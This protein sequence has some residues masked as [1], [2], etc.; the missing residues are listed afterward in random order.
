MIRIKHTLSWA[1]PLLLLAASPVYA[2]PLHGD[3]AG[4]FVRGLLHPLLGID[5]LLAMVAVGVWAA[6]LGGSAVWKV[7]PAF[8]ITMLIGAG[9]GLAGIGLPLIE[10]MIAASVVVLGLVIA[11]QVRM[12]AWLASLLVA[13]FALFHGHA[14]M[15]ELPAGALALNYIVGF[16][17]TTAT[18]HGAGIAM[19]YLLHRHASNALVR[20]GGIGLAGV[21]VWLLTGI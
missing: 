7:P 15:A 6:Q 16:A 20:A 18:L 4:G 21:G 14:H 5:H 2:H 11:T 9:A 12:S 10:P 1:V 8:V 13:V 3:A 17:L 19:G